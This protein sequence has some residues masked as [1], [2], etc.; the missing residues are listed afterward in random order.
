[1]QS[2]TDLINKL[3]KRCEQVG[4]PVT[5]EEL[6]Q[7]QIQ[8]PTQLDGIE[9]VDE[10]MYGHKGDLYTVSLVLEATK[11]EKQIECNKELSLD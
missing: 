1:M 5:Q 7:L 6:L 9:E 2:Q 8:Q 11:E 4:F 10:D 3:L